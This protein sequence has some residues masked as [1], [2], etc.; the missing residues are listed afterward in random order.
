MT[1]VTSPHPTQRA[2]MG[3]K[4]PAETPKATRE[5][6]ALPSVAFAG[7]PVAS[8]MAL[9]AKFTSS[10]RDL[11]RTLKKSADAERRAAQNEQ[12]K[13]LHEKAD[14]MRTS[15]VIQAG[16]LAASTGLQAGAAAFRF[17]S[18][19]H[20]EN[21]SNPKI[22]KKVVEEAATETANA[23]ASSLSA[24]AEI[25]TK[26][27]GVAVAFGDANVV[28]RDAEATEAANRAD[29]HRSVSDEHESAALEAE[30]V[31]KKALE[32]IRAI[33]EAQHRA[34]MALL[35]RLA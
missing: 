14:D 29:H 8:A 35:N 24:S 7:D 22:G 11:S 26:L 33:F 3:A 16:I 30:A 31:T 34:E 20:A 32:A 12:V 19:G 17:K 27:T 18:I 28:L 6:L 1:K 15:G 5:L 21:A 10:S 13:K 23:W 9:V 2:G 25:N 4:E